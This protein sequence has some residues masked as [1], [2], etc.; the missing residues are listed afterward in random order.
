MKTL[1]LTLTAILLS[2]SILAMASEQKIT[3]D[4]IVKMSLLQATQDPDLVQQMY[5]QLDDDFLEGEMVPATV[6]VC[7]VEY[8]GNNI[9]IYGTYEEWCLFFVMDPV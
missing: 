3:K 8:Q 1:R 2:L 9:L 6:L 4:E 7:L 5:I